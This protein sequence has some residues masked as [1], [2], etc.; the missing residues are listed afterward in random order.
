MRYE[1]R[2]FYVGLAFLII[3]VGSLLLLV[4]CNKVKHIDPVRQSYKTSKEA[5]EAVVARIDGTKG[6]RILYPVSGRSMEPIIVAGDCLIVQKVAFEEIVEGK[7]YAF[8]PMS[9]VTAHRAIFKDS[10]GWFMG[11]DNAPVFDRGARMT[12]E[13]IV[14]EIVFIG[15]VETI[16]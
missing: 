7:I 9:D 1:V 15:H 3:G 11:G 8:M 16:L 10:F 6:Q 2:Y 4:G 13:N 5:F 12:A 14:G